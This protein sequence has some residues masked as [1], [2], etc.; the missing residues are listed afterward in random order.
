MADSIKVRVTKEHIERGEEAPECELCGTTENVARCR[1]SICREE[2][3]DG[4]D[5]CKACAN[6]IYE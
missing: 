4:R 6:N 3:P 2:R 1:C 5:L